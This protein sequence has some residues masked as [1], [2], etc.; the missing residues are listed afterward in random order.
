MK[1][2]TRQVSEMPSLIFLCVFRSIFLKIARGN[3][4]RN[5]SNVVLTLL[6]ILDRRSSKVLRASSHLPQ[7]E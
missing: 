7:A 2:D 3:N 6:L 4:L 1:R 5:G